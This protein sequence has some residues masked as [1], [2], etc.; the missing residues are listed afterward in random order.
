M[1]EDS[2]KASYTPNPQHVRRFFEASN[3]LAS[4]C[5]SE[6]EWYEKITG[7]ALHWLE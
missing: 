5:G 1:V 4:T 3:V 7:K 2:Y 6:V